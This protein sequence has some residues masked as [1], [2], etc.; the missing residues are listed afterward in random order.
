MSDLNTRR[1]PWMKFY[2]ADWRADPALRMCSFAARGLWVDLMTLMH[3]AEPYGHLLVSGKAPNAR[4]LSGLLGG[5]AKEIEGL[6]GELEEAGVFSKTEGGIVFS[7]RMTRDHAK[8]QTDKANGR[9]G[10]NP[11]VKANANRGVADGVNLGLTGGDKAQ[12]LEARSQKEEHS[13]EAPLPV[14]RPRAEIEDR[15]ETR[16]IIEA[17][18]AALVEVFGEAYRRDWPQQ[19]DHVHAK[20][21]LDMGWS[22]ATCRPVFVK[23]L[24]Q[25]KDANRKPP[26]GIA[27][28]EKRF[29]DLKPG[30]VSGALPPAIDWQNDPVE[31]VLTELVSKRNNHPKAV[32]DTLPVPTRADAERVLAERRATRTGA[33]A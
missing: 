3:E 18:D 26:G 2:P 31:V 4:Q 7:R 27:F 12:R 21:L 30:A 10:G 13:T 20:R 14:A 11:S 22:A 6:I 24:R 8:A 17:F 19:A 23:S 28:Y 32:R 25:A 33:A 9:K 1:Q 15:S 29:A 16:P 5:S